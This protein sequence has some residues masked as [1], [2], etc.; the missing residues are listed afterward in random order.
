MAA[1]KLTKELEKLDE[2]PIDGVSVCT[3]GDDMFKWVGTIGG[4]EGTPY[5]G[6][7]FEFH[8]DIPK[9]YPKDENWPQFTFLTKIF[10]PNVAVS[11]KVDLP[12]YSVTEVLNGII[13][14]MKMPNVSD[15]PCDQEKTPEPLKLF[16]E[17]KEEFNKKAKEWTEKWAMDNDDDDD[18][19]DE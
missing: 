6:G 5:E 3:D 7:T 14:L 8:I 17:N 15:T 16:K 9:T 11:G 18:D 10:H 13:G 2:S 1:R 4:P 12:K 19:D